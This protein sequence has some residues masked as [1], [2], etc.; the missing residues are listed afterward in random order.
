M[1]VYCVHVYRVLLLLTS[2]DAFLP[3]LLPPLIRPNTHRP[4]HPAATVTRKGRR[5]A[6]VRGN[7]LKVS[8]VPGT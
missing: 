6:D 3:L 4:V 7:A 8:R 2:N 5:R 1:R